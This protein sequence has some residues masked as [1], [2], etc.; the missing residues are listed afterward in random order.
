MA[1]ITDVES[2]LDQIRPKSTIDVYSL[3]RAII[4]QENLGRFHCLKNDAQLFLRT[5]KMDEVLML[6]SDEAVEECLS[7]LR[8]RFN[9]EGDIRGWYITRRAMERYHE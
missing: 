9:I 2:W 6:V 8:R 3:Y 4:D 7:T 1:R 5:D